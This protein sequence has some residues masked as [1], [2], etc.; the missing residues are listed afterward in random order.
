[1]RSRPRNDLQRRPEE[2]QMSVHLSGT[3]SSP[4]CANFALR[5]TAEDNFQQFD[6]EVINTVRRNFYVDDCLKSVPSKEA[7]RLTTDLRRLLERE[8][9]NLTKW[10]SNSR[11][12]IESLP[13]SDRPGSFKDLHDSQMPV[14]RA[15]GFCW[16][17]E[18]D[19]FCFKIEVNDKPLTRRGLLSVVSS[20]QDLLRFAAP[21]ILP[22]K[23]ILRDLCRKKLEW[24]DPIPTE[25][26]ERWLRKL[27]ASC[28]RRKRGSSIALKSI[29]GMESESINVDEINRVEKV[30][31]FVQ[32]HS[33]EEEMS[34]LS[35]KGGGSGDNSSKRG[36]EKERVVKKTSAI[37]KLAPMKID[38][39]LYVGGCLTQA[40]TP[41]A[42]KPQL[43]LLKKH[44][45]VDLIVRHYHLKSGHSGLEHVLSLIRERF[46]ILKA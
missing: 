4:S 19:I 5:K 30:L 20:V 8:G 45:V 28:E 38:D 34:R 16:D 24:D 33:F 39:L 41:N 21:V 13:E 44:H 2:Y 29:V 37:Y 35:Q 10:V 14:E 3:I 46:C 6:F 12:L 1:M 42:A 17:V 31:K 25:E 15:L 18:G 7:I 26:K 9:F 22:A 40:S 32:H 43:I 11:K 27:R 23:A 36:K